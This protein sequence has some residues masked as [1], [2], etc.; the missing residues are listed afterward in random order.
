MAI[1][2]RK[3]PDTF[4]DWMLRALGKER[5]YIIPSARGEPSSPYGYAVT[6]KESFWN[7]LARPKG[8]PLPAGR[9]S[10][11]QMGD[12]LGCRD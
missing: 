2:L 9:I 5:A 6:A 12:L 1:K 8:A 3:T 10:A 4:A 11:R 7:A